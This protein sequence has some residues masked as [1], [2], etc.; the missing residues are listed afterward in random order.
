MTGIILEGI[1]FAGKSRLLANLRAHPALAARSSLL[2]LGSPYTEDGAGE[3]SEQLMY[4]LLAA[5]E[6][7]R[8][9]TVESAGLR[10]DAGARLLYVFERFHLTNIL[11]H[12]G[13]DRGML[14][15]V[16]GMMR[17]YRPTTVLLTVSEE[18]LAQR[19]A[20]AGQP[21]GRVGELLAQQAAYEDLAANCS[22]PTI[23]VPADEDAVERVARLL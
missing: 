23:I 18:V 1:P 12:A 13:G 4:S 16:E 7:L 15:R 10:A 6:P 11:R 8:V 19:L 2:L 5:L 22:L 20:A 21:A 14:K 17:F 3:R 9:L